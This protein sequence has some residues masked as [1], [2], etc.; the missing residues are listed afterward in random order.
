[1]P[2]RVVLRST[3]LRSVG[4][5]RLAGADAEL[6][7]PAGRRVLD[8]HGLDVK[9]SVPTIVWAA[10]T[11]KSKPLTIRLTSVALRHCEVLLVDDGAG[12][13]T[14]ADAFLPKTPSPPSSG[15]ARSFVIDHA[16]LESPLGARLARRQRRRSNVEV[17]HALGSLRSTPDETAIA[18][19]RAQHSWR[20][21]SHKAW[22][23][24]RAARH[25]EHPRRPRQ[26]ARSAR[27]HYEGSAA[28]IPIVL[29]ASYLDSKIVA[30]LSAAS[31]P[32]AAL[33][34]SRFRVWSLRS[35][36]SLSASAARAIARAPRNGRA[37][38]RHGQARRR[39]RLAP[40]TT[41]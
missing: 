21:A 32:P 33:S 28:A 39:L 27:A 20:G 37:W 14:L 36:A 5:T 1:M 18:I 4:L 8:I 40:R 38:G 41:T 2:S 10:L 16:E 6:F 22:T 11:Q 3:A 9:L 30:H 15:P 24:R 19:Q 29:D 34:K 25:V 13:P 35:P 31:I 26:A 7:D 23:R 17:K 12:S